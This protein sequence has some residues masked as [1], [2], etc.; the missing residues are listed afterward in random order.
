MEPVDLDD[1]VFEDMNGKAKKAMAFVN[2]NSGSGKAQKALNIMRPIF[3]EANVELIIKETEYAG[4]AIDMAREEDLTEISYLLGIGGDGTISEVVNGFYARDDVEEVK[5]KI[6]MGVIPAGTGNTRL[7]SGH[8]L[9]R[10]RCQGS[11]WQQG[12]TC[13]RDTGHGA[14]RR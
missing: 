14:R 7:R 10:A 9:D 5:N 4:H 6:V 3:K 8:R 2:P 11:C 12:S 13:G 1:I